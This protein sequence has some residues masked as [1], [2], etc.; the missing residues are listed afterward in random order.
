MADYDRLIE[1]YISIRDRKNT[2]AKAQK[3]AM[4][5]FTS[6][7]EKIENALLKELN[8]N[9][10]ESAKTLH[11]TAFKV[12]K[13]NVKIVDWDVALDYLMENDMLH[14]LERRL[15]KSGVQ[16]YVES[17]GENLPGTSIDCTTVVQI[18]RS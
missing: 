1:S 11:G 3:E 13:S 8:A 5:P 9:N 14:L 10:Q 12:I 2:L 6:A 7:L 17:N 18:R 16:E 15:A 4:M